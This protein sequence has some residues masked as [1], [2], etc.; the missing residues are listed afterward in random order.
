MRAERKLPVNLDAN[1]KVPDAVYE[2]DVNVP[3]TVNTRSTE[4]VRKHYW[5]RWNAENHEAIEHYNVRIEREGL[6]LARYRSFMQ[7]A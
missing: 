1:A 5:Q 2:Q 3:P 4:S 7:R 6:P